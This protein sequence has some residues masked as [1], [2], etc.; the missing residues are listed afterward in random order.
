MLGRKWRTMLNKATAA[1]V[2]AQL[3]NNETCE[4]SCAKQ[5]TVWSGVSQSQRSVEP[6]FVV[7]VSKIGACYHRAERHS[8]VLCCAVTIV[9]HLQFISRCIPICITKAT[10]GF[11]VAMF[12]KRPTQNEGKAQQQ[13]SSIQSNSSGRECGRVQLFHHLPIN[14]RNCPTMTCSIERR[15]SAYCNVVLLQSDGK[16]INCNVYLI[17]RR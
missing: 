2:T 6:V 15:P 17:Q 14:H 9:F 1:N 10:V 16:Q 7:S 3:E 4:W 5:C 12:W 8:I 13:F 11:G